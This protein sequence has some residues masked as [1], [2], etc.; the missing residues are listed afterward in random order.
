MQ[1]DFYVLDT[2]SAQR[3][4]LHVCH[5]VEKAYQDQQKVYL[6]VN[7][8]ADAERLDALLW[9]YK[10]DSFLPHQIYQETDYPPPIQIGTGNPPSDQQDL[11]INL[12]QQIPGFYTQFKR[13]IE[14]IYTDTNIQQLGRERFK[15][16]RDQGCQINT[17]K[18]KANEL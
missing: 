16:Y 17:Y 14:I 2:P 8:P 10:E 13:V 3:A 9:T 4:W 11:L 5:L 1:V 7:T 12:N 15:Q 18:I 6:H